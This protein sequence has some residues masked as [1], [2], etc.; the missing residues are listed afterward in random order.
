MNNGRHMFI[1]GVTLLKDVFRVALWNRMLSFIFLTGAFISAITE[2]LFLALLY[3]SF[4][5]DRKSAVISWVKTNVYFLNPIQL[6]VIAEHFTY[7]LISSA[8]IMLFVRLFF[9]ISSRFA[10]ARIQVSTT[11]QLSN[12]LLSAFIDAH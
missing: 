10:L 1:K 3:A 12:K 4:S 9:A 6:N 7:V 2:M 5:L 11:V 8:V